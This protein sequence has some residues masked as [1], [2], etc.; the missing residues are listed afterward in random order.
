MQ[1][2]AIYDMDKTITA[3]PTWTRF[4]VYAA[5]A[6][7]PW[8]L[9]LLPLAGAA[10]LGYLLKLVDRPGLKQLSHRLLLGPALGEA[11]LAAVAEKFA[12][13]ELDKGVLHGAQERIAADR[14][15]GYRLVMATASHG[16]Y[17]AAIGR[18]LGFDDVIAT[19]AK[20]D[21]QGRILSLIEGDNCYG[22]VKLRMIESWMEG[23]GVSRRDVHV[24]AY[25]DHVSDAP[26]L[27]WADEPFAVNAH[28]PLRILA[29]ARGWPQLDWR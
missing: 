26:L 7:A 23:A 21:G 1:H 19:Q 27:E 22:P 12:A 4:L 17:A 10:G 25:S 8:R 15:A 14:A 11:D 6:R 20:R 13:A 28:G 24:R 2:L 16:Y 9:G 18:L 29:Q 3:A 5:R